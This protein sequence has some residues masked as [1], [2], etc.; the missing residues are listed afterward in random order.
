M[1]R[2]ART[3]AAMLGAMALGLAG[4]ALAGAHNEGTTDTAGIPRCV[5][6][7]YN[8]GTQDVCYTVRVT[9]GA[10]LVIDHADTVVSTSGADVTVAPCEWW[11]DTA[12]PV[13]PANTR[14]D[15]CVSEDGTLSTPQ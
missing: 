4:L 11:A 14:D 5:N 3:A 7:D 13:L 2:N 10:F 15:A 12:R 8:D 9:D 6:D 1:I